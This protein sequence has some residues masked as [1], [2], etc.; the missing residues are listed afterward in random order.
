LG[1][2]GG[3]RKEADD[4]E[5]LILKSGWRCCPLWWSSFEVGCCSVLL[6]LD[7]VVDSLVVS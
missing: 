3:G 7:L 1:A 5:W 6:L 2:A 4:H